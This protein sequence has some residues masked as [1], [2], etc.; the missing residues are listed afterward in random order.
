MEFMGDELFFT[1]STE[2]TNIIWENRHWGPADY[3]KR[4]MIAFAIITVLLLVS[5]SIIYF[6]KSFS[7][8]M[9]D[10]Y[11]PVD[12]ANIKATYVKGGNGLEYYATI[13]HQNYYFFDASETTAVP[14]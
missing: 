10:K 8:K 9:N 6:S 5:F 14:L 12:C 4:G 13:E 2:P 3:F 7:T 1:E 11:P